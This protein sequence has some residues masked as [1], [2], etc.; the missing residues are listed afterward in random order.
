MPM[1]V[2]LPGAKL[3][4]REWPGII[5]IGGGPTIRARGLDTSDRRSARG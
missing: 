1:P 2:D 5:A 4:A 3:L